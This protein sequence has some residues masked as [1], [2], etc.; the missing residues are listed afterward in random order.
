MRPDYV[1]WL[2][3]G[4]RHFAADFYLTGWLEGL[5]VGYDVATDEDL[6]RLGQDLLS[7]YRVVVT[8]SHPE[9]VT[10][11]EYDALAGYA[12]AGGRIM[13]LGANGFFWVTSF[14]DDTRAAVEC[15]RGFAAQ[16]NW[17]SHPAETFHSSTGE[18]GGAW[19]HRG[20]SSRELFGVGMCAAGWGPASGYTRTETS[21]DPELAF[22]FE[23][24]ADERLGAEGLVLG[25][26]AGDELD[27]ADYAHGTPLH[28]KVLLSS[29]H[30]ARYLPTLEAVQSI[31]PDCDGT[32]NDEVRSDVVLLETAR[33]GM[34]FS[35]G[36]ICWAGAMAVRGYDNDVARLTGNV[37]RRFLRHPDGV[38]ATAASEA[39]DDT[40]GVGS[41]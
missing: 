25:G 40:M 5:G 17:T 13:Y 24:V 33:G 28:A 38:P 37:L 21:R 3:A 7:R 11:R 29:R 10:S 26:A 1:T 4:R 31:E 41:D 27:S 34:V 39:L 12:R 14:T 36:S 19:L 22:A 30:G 15:R 16:R 18:Q 32:H 2:T 23:G 9:Y 20:R 8:G 6:D 35:V